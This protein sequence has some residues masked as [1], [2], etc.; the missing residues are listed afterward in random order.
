M[1]SLIHK[2]LLFAGGGAPAVSVSPS[3]WDAGSTPVGTPVSQEFTIENTGNATLEITLPITV[4]GA[5]ASAFTVTV[6]PAVT[7]LAPGASTTFTVQA[8]ADVMDA[9]SAN[10]SIVNNSATNPKLVAITAEVLAF[11]AYILS[12]AGII[13]YYPM[14]DTSGSTTV[15]DKNNYDGT[16]GGTRTLAN[17]VF[18]QGANVVTLT[19]GYST[20]PEANL[21]AIWDWSKGWWL[22]FAK[23]TLASA[24]DGVRHQIFEFRRNNDE[25]IDW[26]KD[27]DNYSYTIVVEIGNVRRTVQWY[28]VREEWCLFALTWDTVANEIKVYIDGV[29]MDTVTTATPILGAVATPLA[30]IG[31]GFNPFTG[32]MGHHAIGAGSTISETQLNN[33]YKAVMGTTREITFAGDSKTNFNDYWPTLLLSALKTET[34]DVWRERCKR[35]AVAGYTAAQLLTV[36]QASLS[37]AIGEPEA[38]LL[39]VGAND[40]SGGTIEATFKTALTGIINAYRTQFPDTPVYVA[41]PWRNDVATPTSPATLKTW[42]Q[43]VIATYP[44]GVFAG[45]DETVW[46][47]N[48]IAT[49]SADG[50]HYNAAGS[51]EVVNQWLAVLGY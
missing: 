46:F 7:S 49:Y 27:F 42:I 20:L 21:R 47:A 24:T 3:T 50:A 4:V 44:S 18:P 16:Y 23:P 51:V 15:D 30:F 29:L 39:N 11:D 17:A 34:A 2:F 33:L 13:A 8:D 35:F 25:Q 14:D 32:G 5:E 12:F 9:F 36:L 28:T 10:I 41:F 22:G 26:Y 1:L 40:Q 37:S 38:V 45:H 31:T 43:A 6:Q 48:N 19:Q